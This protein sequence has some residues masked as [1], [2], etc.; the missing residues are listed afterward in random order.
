MAIS[1]QSIQTAPRSH[2]SKVTHALRGERGFATT[3]KTALGTPSESFLS[4][5]SAGRVPD[6]KPNAM[7][8]HLEAPITGTAVVEVVAKVVR[9]AKRTSPVKESTR[10]EESRSPKSADPNEEIDT[11]S[12]YVEGAIKQ[13]SKAPDSPQ[14]DE[15]TVVVAYDAP[16]GA[17]AIRCSFS[18]SMRPDVTEGTGEVA[19]NDS[20]LVFANALEPEQ[21]ALPASGELVFQLSLQTVQDLPPCEDRPTPHSTGSVNPAKETL[22]SEAMEFSPVT[23]KVIVAPPQSAAGEAEKSSEEHGGKADLPQESP[24]A[25]TGNAMHKALS[26]GSLIPQSPSSLVSHTGRDQS[27]LQSPTTRRSEHV[28]PLPPPQSAPAVL[29]RMDVILRGA[30]QVVR[31]DIRQSMG[32]VRVA[33][34]SDDAAL[35]ARLRDSLPELLNRLDD[36]GLQARVTSLG[37]QSTIPSPA[38]TESGNTAGKDADGSSRDMTWHQQ[39][40]K[41][42]NPQRAWRAA[43]W[44]LHEE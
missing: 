25:T 43:T 38:R 7:E 6:A 8:F 23:N 15:D 14:S 35:A 12:G 5:R 33:V 22:D 42:R 20:K 41:E 3:L 27:S 31:L 17:R 32:S 44:K 34:H 9:G 2:D 24:Q 11:K 26:D 36:R 37:G 21:G 18:F 40:Q 29:Q 39:Q 13:S 16:G 10:Q 30:D 4:P 19:S 28:A 1:V